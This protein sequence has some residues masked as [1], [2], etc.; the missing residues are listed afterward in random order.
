VPSCCRSCFHQHRSEDSAEGEFKASRGVGSGLVLAGSGRLRE[1][2]SRP[3]I[4]LSLHGVEDAAKYSITNQPWDHTASPMPARGNCLINYI[5]LLVLT[6]E[7]ISERH[8]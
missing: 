4:T 7:V 2:H 8:S 6:I 5:A 3:M 1:A